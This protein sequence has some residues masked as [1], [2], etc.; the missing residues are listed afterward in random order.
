[1][2]SILVLAFIIMMA[3][4][5]SNQFTALAGRTVHGD[6]ASEECDCGQNNGL[7]YDE[8][9]WARCDCGGPNAPLECGA[10]RASTPQ[11]DYLSGVMIFLFAAFLTR[12]IV[13]IP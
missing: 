4:M 12:R 1:L 9:S 10:G 2:F 8:N 11:D 6:A 5:L 13:K 3:P 7:C